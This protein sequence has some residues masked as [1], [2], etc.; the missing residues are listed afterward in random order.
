MT[1]VAQA[2]D[3]EAKPFARAFGVALALQERLGLLGSGQETI[4]V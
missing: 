1:D 3:Y 4:V 2:I